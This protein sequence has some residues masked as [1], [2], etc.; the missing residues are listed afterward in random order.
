MEI[1]RVRAECGRRD[2]TKL[3]VASRNFANMP[4]EGGKNNAVIQFKE[5]LMI[6]YCTLEHP[7]L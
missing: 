2:I 3:A 5:A 6:A 7:P 4:K 1:R